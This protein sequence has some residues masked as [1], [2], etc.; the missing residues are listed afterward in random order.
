MSKR[1]LR[2]SSIPGVALFI[3]CSL[4]GSGCE[5]D[6]R[7]VSGTV[8]VQNTPLQSGSVSA[9]ERSAADPGGWAVVGSSAIGS[10]GTYVIEN[11]PEGELRF[12]VESHPRTPPGLGGERPS[13][14]PK[15]HA[16]YAKPSTSDLQYV[17]DGTDNTFDINLTA[18]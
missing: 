1:F 14:V 8:R 17:I 16:R 11:V 15:V 9:F 5:S 13:A 7:R 10:N 12:V 6:V 18:P 2:S 3:G 4:V